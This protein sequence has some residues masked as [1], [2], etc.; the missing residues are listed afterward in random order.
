MP[1]V[2]TVL[3]TPDDL[4]R[5]LAHPKQFEAEINRRVKP[6]GA[7]VVGIYFEKIGGPAYVLC[8]GDEGAVGKVPGAIGGGDHTRLHRPDEL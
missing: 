7:S 3:A 8:Q 5:L 1:L 2:W 4:K 6:T